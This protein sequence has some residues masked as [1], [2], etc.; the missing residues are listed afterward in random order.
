MFGCRSRCNYFFYPVSL[1]PQSHSCVS[2]CSLRIAGE[3]ASAEKFMAV[4]QAPTA[5]V[6][7]LNVNV[8]GLAVLKFGQRHTVV[9][10][11]NPDNVM[12]ASDADRFNDGFREDV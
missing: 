5:S 9:G 10:Y 8:V 12:L 6:A 1:D 7:G 4:R 3:S 2:V 11:L